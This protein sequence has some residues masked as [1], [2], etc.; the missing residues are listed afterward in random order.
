VKDYFVL[1]NELGVNE[2]REQVYTKLLGEKIGE[3]FLKENIVLS[4][5]AVAFGAFE[6]LKK[7]LRENDLF[8]VLRLPEEDFVFDQ[9]LFNRYISVLQKALIDAEQAGRLKL[10]RKIRGSVQELIEDGI[11]NLGVFHAKKPIEINNQGQ[12]VSEDFKVLFYYHNRL[13]GYELD[14]EVEDRMK[15]SAVTAKNA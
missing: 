6:V 14:L 7:Q 12:L 10:S 1:N 8:S 4:S 3:R 11:R 5:H 13:T 15:S 2:Q 9:E